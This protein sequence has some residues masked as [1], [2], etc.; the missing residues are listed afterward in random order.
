V[1]RCCETTD[2]GA[3]LGENHDGKTTKDTRTAYRWRQYTALV[4]G[5]HRRSLI[6]PTKEEIPYSLRLT[7]YEYNADWFE[8]CAYLLFAT[9][10]S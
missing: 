3:I 2:L 9:S 1:S 4:H 8:K 10:V 6:L 5:Y 7:F